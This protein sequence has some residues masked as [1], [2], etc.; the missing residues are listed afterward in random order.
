MIPHISDATIVTGKMTSL[1]VVHVTGACQITDVGACWLA[2]HC[3]QLED[4]DVS[5]VNSL[6][7]RFLFA[8]GTHSTR[9]KYILLSGLGHITDKGMVAM[10]QGCPRIVRLDCIGCARLTDVSVKAI[11]ALK[12]LHAINLSSCDEVTD[13]GILALAENCYALK[14]VNISNLA[15][16]SKISIAKL[17]RTN[18]QLVTLNAQSCNIVPADYQKC[19]K[20]LPFASPAHSKCLLEPRHRSVVAFNTWVNKRNDDSRTI[21]CIQALMRGWVQRKKFQILKLRRRKS[22]SL[23]QRVWRGSVSRAETTKK[24]KAIRMLHQNAR[25]LQKQMRRMMAVRLARRKRINMRERLIATKFLQRC[26]RGFLTRKRLFYRFKKR[27]V[28]RSRL[29]Y[30]S[31]KLF[32]LRS[33][34]E[35]HRKIVKAQSIGKM[36]SALKQYGRLKLGFEKLQV[37]VKIHLA[38]HRVLNLFADEE[39]ERL[40]LREYAA[41]IIGRSWRAKMWNDMVVAFTKLCA[42]HHRNE[43]DLLEWVGNRRNEAAIKIQALHR[44]ARC[45]Y[46]IFLKNRAAREG[47]NS[48]IT[49]QKYIRRF[50]ARCKFLRWRPYMKRVSAL[51]RKL[52]KSAIAY[53]YAAQA[54]VIQRFFKRVVFITK[55][56][57]A[58]AFINRVGRGHLGRN[59]MR[60]KIYAIHTTNA[61]KIQRAWREYQRRRHQHFIHCRNHLAARR[62]QVQRC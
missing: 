4:V 48:A 22:A 43:M 51:W 20:H 62:I 39:I 11:S 59:I 13:D 14:Y 28:I 57:R 12:K 47:W 45:R 7:D 33:V 9:L 56:I 61:V 2:E 55:R 44:G 58:A 21:V 32:I 26:T 15:E 54:K 5:F 60:A 6:T 19:C 38:A 29:F 35:T 36:Y 46:K 18:V 30:L 17:T 42:I 50:I 53:F 3:K 23:I 24:T 49:A 10:C 34:R 16:V 1:R 8:L 25:N 52:Y 27:K 31:Q 41:I 40:T 37:L